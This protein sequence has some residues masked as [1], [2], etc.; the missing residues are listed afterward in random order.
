MD[1]KTKGL[2]KKYNVERVDGKPVDQCFV[3]ELK[4]PLTHNA[5]LVWSAEL[6]R[7]GYDTLAFDIRQLVYPAAEKEA[8]KNG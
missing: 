6:E 2:Y 8:A 7:A 1:D 3:L 5:L 4:D